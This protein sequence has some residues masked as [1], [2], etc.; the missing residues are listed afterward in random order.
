MSRVL[1][2]H[3]FLSQALKR[4]KRAESC[5]FSFH[6]PK[7][8]HQNDKNAKCSFSLIFIWFSHFVPLINIILKFLILISDSVKAVSSNNTL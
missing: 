4:F 1:K 5:S 8:S 7:S 2:E 3:G 6:F